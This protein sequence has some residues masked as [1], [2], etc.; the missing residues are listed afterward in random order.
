MD[1]L[2]LFWLGKSTYNTSICGWIDTFRF[3]RKMDN[4]TTSQTDSFA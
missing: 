1:D 3:R 2:L 4:D